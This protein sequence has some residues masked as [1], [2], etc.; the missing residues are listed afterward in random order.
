VQKLK[1]ES[2]KY[3][4]CKFN[5]PKDFL[6]LDV[7]QPKKGEMTLSM[8]TFT[9]RMATTLKFRAQHEGPILT[10][11]RT[12]KKI[13]KGLDPEPNEQY[14]SKVGIL[15]RLTMGI[16]FDLVYVTKKLSRVL[17]ESTK[18]A[19]ELVDRAIE[20]TIKQ[21]M[22]TCSFPMNT[23]SFPISPLCR[24]RARCVLHNSIGPNCPQ[25]HQHQSGTRSAPHA[26][27]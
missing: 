11:G 5:P 27:G 7:T 17:A 18:I 1:D 23:C 4:Q 22:L 2:A 12:D 13:I 26:W 16:R 6:G 19:N 15:N 25:T 21:V 9:N 8:A 24:A 14:R 10:P 3:F 20:Y